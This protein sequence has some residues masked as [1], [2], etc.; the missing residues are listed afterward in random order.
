[1]PYSVVYMGT[2]EFAA[3]PLDALLNGGYAVKLVI[4]Q[5]DRARDRGRRVKP[6]PVKETALKAGL[7]VLQPEKLRGNE[8]LFGRIR[9]AGPD[10]IV[11]A[12]Y[13]R[14]LPP[15]LLEIPRFGCINIHASLLPRFRGAAPVQR[16]IMAGDEK[17][18]ITLMHMA[19]GLDTG[20]MIAR[21]ETTVRG[22]NA[23]EL[24]AELSD[25]GAKLLISTLPSVA[26]GTAAREPQDDSLATY[27]PMIEKKEGKVDFSGSAEYIERL[28]RALYPGTGAYAMYGDMRVKILE[29]DVMRSG[30]S[31]QEPGTII[32]TGAEG[33]FVACGEGELI[34]K[35]LQV[36]GKK[37]V[38]AADYLKGNTMEGRLT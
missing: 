1:M 28:A 9:D 32:K 31:G 35:K 33:I 12:A 37:P 8:E 13:G 38:S 14:I 6:S 36:Q 11:V 30:N 19:E 5:P 18:G 15:E 20:D 25:M 24:T 4:T 7:E 2:P 23:G 22:K 27:A 16:C 26:D 34:I 10:F 3:V 29:A 21:A 17:T